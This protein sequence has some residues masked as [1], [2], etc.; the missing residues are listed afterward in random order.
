MARIAENKVEN[1]VIILDSIGALESKKVLKDAIDKNDIKDDQG[2]VTRKIKR[3]LKVM[4]SL[5]KFNNSM[6]ITCGHIYSDPNAFTEKIYGGNYFKLSSDIILRLYK[7]SI[8]ENPNGKTKKEKGKIIGN[9]IIAYSTKNRIA[10]P[11][12]TAVLN[13]DFQKGVDK[14]AGIIDL[15]LDIGFI[16]QSGAWYTCDDL[17]IKSQG[18][19]NLK[20]DLYSANYNVLLDKIED[21]L[22]TTGYSSVNRELEL[23][24]EKNEESQADIPNDDIE[25]PE[26]DKVT[27]GGNP[28]KI[29]SSSTT[30][31]KKSTGR[32][33]K[34]SK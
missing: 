6:L 24:E 12:Q 11:Y 19:E 1:I 14:L 2:Q 9:E 16:K 4:V 29:E 17:N 7:T 21:H 26:Y 13:I 25:P 8:Y 5:V 3:L 23:Q 22:K 18:I 34:N 28:D 27:E 20:K 32:P 30:K 31:K 15:C 10:P 33:K